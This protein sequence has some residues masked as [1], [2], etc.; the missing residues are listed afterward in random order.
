MK[1]DLKYYLLIVLVFLLLFA[2][3]SSSD[4]PVEYETTLAHDDKDPYGAQVLNDLMP[5]I[6][7]DNEIYYNRFT[8]YE[9][10]YDFTPGVNL[11]IIAEFFGAGEEDIEVL[12]DNVSR[13]MNALVVA[14]NMPYLEEELDFD[15][16]YDQFSYMISADQDSSTLSFV[17]SRL[18]DQDFKYKRDAI[19]SYFDEVKDLSYEV[20]AKNKDGK[21]I[22]IRVKR[23]EGA[24]ILC[25]TPLAFTNN[26]MFFEDNHEF[27]STMLSF[28]PE[29]DLI[30]TEYYQLG[31][32]EADTRMRVILNTPP[33]RLAYFITIAAVLLFMLFEAKRKQRII[34]I[35]KPLSNTTLEFIGT[36]ANLYLRK[37][38]HTDIA[39]K[40]IQYFQEYIH[41]HYFMSFKKFDE[42]FF[43]KLAAKSGNSVVDVKK[44]FELIR[45]IKDSK[46]VSMNELKQLSDKIEAFY[47]RK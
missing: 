36:I 47:G 7:G 9:L 19:N 13:G 45:K 28:L 43:E 1:G 4:G 40:R 42:H 25:S 30:W 46:R 24:L 39:L 10:E 17:N 27:V 14:E 15:T 5:E 32:V 3:E 23:G 37:K 41:T 16:D 11:L 18:P 38:D 26:Y 8:L 22:A 33:L 6:L 2:A 21:P 20:I 29:R 35:V 31:R 34:P 12:L 44:L